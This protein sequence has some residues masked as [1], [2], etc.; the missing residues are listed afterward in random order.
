MK[1]QLKLKQGQPRKLR[2]GQIKVIYS[3]HPNH[4]TGRRGIANIEL[5]IEGFSGLGSNN[6][7]H[8]G[9]RI[10]L[11]GH[12]LVDPWTDIHYLPAHL[13]CILG[14]VNG[15]LAVVAEVEF[16]ALRAFAKAD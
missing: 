5:Q 13:V 11:A 1:W 8:Q 7:S 15:E 16:L 9:A 14:G 4:I 2:V 3:S 6:I 10:L 12:C